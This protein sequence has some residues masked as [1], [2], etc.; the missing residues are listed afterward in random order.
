MEPS[1]QPALLTKKQV[2]E[3][4]E[5][6]TMEL[7]LM[8]SQRNELRDLLLFIS[9]GT[10]DNRPYHKP[11]PFYEKLKIEHKQVICELK[12]FENENTEASEKLS[13]L[14]KETVFYRGLHSRLLIEQ[15]QLN[16]KVDML[17]QEKKKL[18]EDWVLLKHHLEDLNL[19]CKKQDEETSDMKIQQQQEQQMKNLEKLT[20]QLHHMTCERNELRGILANYGNKDLNNRSE[21]LQIQLKQDTEQEDSL[22]QTA[23]EAGAIGVTGNPWFCLAYGPASLLLGLI[24][25]LSNTA[26]DRT[27]EVKEA[28]NNLD[29][30]I[31]HPKIKASSEE[32]TL[33]S[34]KEA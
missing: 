22:L 14:T 2:K 33:Q 15:T 16:K 28:T 7:Q 27:E 32:D 34:P 12:I 24:A 11:N 19:I 31:V 29:D 21:N 30:G 17:R 23:P 8:T 26:P 9:D 5:R 6:L 18:Q 25:F 20:L 4:M 3:E 1:S 13:E 10:V